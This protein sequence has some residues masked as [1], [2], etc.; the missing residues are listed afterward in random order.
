ME[1]TKLMEIERLAEEIRSVKDYIY[2][3]DSCVGEYRI[4]EDFSKAIASHL[5]DIGYRKVEDKN[6]T[7]PDF[8]PSCGNKKEYEEK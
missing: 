8:C 4:S 6:E 7:I 1:L 3:G 2:Q 5:N